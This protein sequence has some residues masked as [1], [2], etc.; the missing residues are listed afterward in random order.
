MQLQDAQLDDMDLSNVVVTQQTHLNVGPVVLEFDLGID[1]LA[2]Q[3]QN[4]CQVLF[5]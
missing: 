4:K 5:Q 1:L 2:K 3:I